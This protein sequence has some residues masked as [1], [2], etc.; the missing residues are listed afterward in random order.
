MIGAGG[1]IANIGAH[2]RNVDLHL[3]TLWS[4]N[5]SITTRLV[6]TVSTPMLFKSVRF[7]R[8]DSDEAAVRWAKS[9]RSCGGRSRSGRA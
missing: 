7:R 1:V 3:E 2:G 9:A 4:Q 8:A 6:D 5:I